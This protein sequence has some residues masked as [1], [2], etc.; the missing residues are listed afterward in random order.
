MAIFNWDAIR[1]TLFTEGQGEVPF[2]SRYVQVYMQLIL[3]AVKAGFTP[4]QIYEDARATSELVEEDVRAGNFD[5]N[6]VEITVRSTFFL[7]TTRL[8]MGMMIEAGSLQALEL[9]GYG[10]SNKMFLAGPEWEVILDEPE[11]LD[12][13]PSL[14][15]EM[16]SGPDELQHQETK[17]EQTDPNDQFSSSIDATNTR[18]GSTEAVTGMDI[19]TLALDSNNLSRRP[20]RSNSSEVD[21][22]G[23]APS[24]Y[25][26]S[27]SEFAKI[28]AN[29]GEFRNLLPHR[30]R[31]WEKNEESHFET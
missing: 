7:L 11:T 15:W 9:H 27:T 16:A 17:A 18:A 21:C 10:G 4:K 13:D 12:T 31:I 30:I 19:K 24:D 29:I 6:S 20:G 5:R 1:V 8:T 22:P 3:E 14:N 2:D 23:N 26:P 25:N 28:M